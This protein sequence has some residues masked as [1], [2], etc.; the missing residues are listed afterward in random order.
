MTVR[1][2]ARKAVGRAYNIVTNRLSPET[3][4]RIDYWSPR[5]REGWG[6]PLNGQSHRQRIVRE[7]YQK[8]AFTETL[9]TGSFRGH[10]TTFFAAVS[11]RPV[12]SVESNQRFL[13]YA[14]RNCAAYREIEC[15]G[16]DSRPFVREMIGKAVG[17][18][19]CYLDAHWYKDLP[20]ADEVATVIKSGVSAVVMIDDF[21]VPRDP[22]YLFDDYGPGARL[23]AE[24]LESAPLDGW[25]WFYPSCPSADETG[26]RRG[27]VVLCSSDLMRPLSELASLRP[28]T[29]ADT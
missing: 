20:L 8:I 14:R 2:S 27:C 26:L 23:T 11:G 13:E 12:R 16:G 9:E 15:Y 22:G 3:A 19:F 28:R 17:P 24:L 10:S 1:T 18:V 29:A 21:Q 7:L 4:A 6:G 5:F 25:G